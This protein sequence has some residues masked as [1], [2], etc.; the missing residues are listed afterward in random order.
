MAFDAGMLACVIEEINRVAGGARTEKVYQPEKDT[1]VLQMR[2]FAG[3][4]RLL[5]NAYTARRK[6]R[7]R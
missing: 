2:T 7:G 1:V 5:I 4:K 6:D 3:G